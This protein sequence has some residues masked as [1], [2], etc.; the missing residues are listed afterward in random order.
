[1]LP[2]SEERPTTPDVPPPAATSGSNPDPDG[3][4]NAYGSANEVS[5]VAR[6]R[7]GGREPSLIVVALLA[8]AA[9]LAAAGIVVYAA[10]S[11]GGTAAPTP[12][13]AIPTPASIA[14][15]PAAA[16]TTAPI[17]PLATPA[18]I[19]TAPVA[20]AAIA[21][22]DA[23]PGTA[24]LEDVLISGGCA[25]SPSC[26]AVVSTRT[27]AHGIQISA[28]SPA[29]LRV[30][31]RYNV[32]RAAVYI[33]HNSASVLTFRVIDATDPDLPKQSGAMQVSAAQSG[34]FQMPFPRAAQKVSLS[35]DAGTV[36]LIGYVE[37][38]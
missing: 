31:G 4:A 38:T 36:D 18:V 37:A 24:R 20:T 35:I 21:G 27:L 32:L 22:V 34:S 26:P 15:V 3:M 33:D 5:G 9:L 1:M 2:G 12:L 10:A 17:V 6:S 16:A 28:G 19:A 25:I 13:I 29:M 30:D 11:S 8:L 14:I 23:A 7:P